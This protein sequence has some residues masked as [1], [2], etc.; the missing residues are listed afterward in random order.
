[1]RRIQ[2][3]F[4]GIRALAV[5]FLLPEEKEVRKRLGFIVNTHHPPGGHHP[6]TL[7]ATQMASWVYQL[8]WT[9]NQSAPV[10]T[11][12]LFQRDVLDSPT[13]MCLP[14][15]RASVFLRQR[16]LE[17]TVTG[18]RMMRPSLTSLRICWPETGGNG[19][20]HHMLPSNW[21][22]SQSF[23]NNRSIHSQV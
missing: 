14:L 15:R 12:N 20:L 18:L 4:S 3:S 9:Y 19:E 6:I 11:L 8:L 10:Q 2:I 16:A 21:S 1:M 7:V 22:C 17:W 23:S 13:P 5:P